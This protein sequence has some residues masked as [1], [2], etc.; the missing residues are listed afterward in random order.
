MKTIIYTQ[1]V[2]IVDSYQERRDC[3]DQRIAEFI[4][5]CGFLPIPVP[6]R[7]ELAEE[8]IMNLKPSG[9]VLTGGNSLVAY[10]G[11]AAERDAMD[12]KL[13]E[14]AINNTIP[15]YGFCRG[16]QSILDYFGNQLIDVEGHVAVRHLVQE[17][18]GG[19]EVNSYH[20]QACVCL[21]SDCG[22]YV[23]AQSAD[24]VI[25]AICHEKLPMIGTMWHPEREVHFSSEDIIRVKKIFNLER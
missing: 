16:M 2:E 8:I 4:N 22:L 18:L 7:S 5:A 13:I 11:N 1:R 19:Y 25:E 15:L 21:K 9:I 24:G 6:N 12:K 10:G 20:N 23:T 17:R 14:L 3:A